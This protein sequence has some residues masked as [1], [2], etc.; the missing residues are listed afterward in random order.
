MVGWLGIFIVFNASFNKIFQLC[1]LFSRA[2]NF[3][4][5][6]TKNRIILLQVNSLIFFEFYPNFLLETSRDGG[7]VYV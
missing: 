3:F 6:E 4:V 7:V 1:R 2:R 5:T